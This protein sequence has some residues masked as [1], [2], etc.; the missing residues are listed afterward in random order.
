MAQGR[1]SKGNRKRN[2]ASQALA[3]QDEPQTREVEVR[4]Q[5]GA[6]VDQPGD[7]IT[8]TSSQSTK[9]RQKEGPNMTDI[10]FPD[11]L[12]DAFFELMEENPA[13]WSN[14]KNYSFQKKQKWEE[15]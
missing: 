7:A 1:K 5:W 3:T 4:S 12:L 2:E 6:A 15:A 13:L 9:R 10:H 14:D 8:Q 11:K